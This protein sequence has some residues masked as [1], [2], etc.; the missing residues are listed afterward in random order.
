MGLQNP[1]NYSLFNLCLRRICPIDTKQIESR[2]NFIASSTSYVQDARIAPITT[3][4]LMKYPA[5]MRNN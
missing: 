5:S 3:E 2:S 4:I 1:I